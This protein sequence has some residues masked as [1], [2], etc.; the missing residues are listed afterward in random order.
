MH[1][2]WS[3]LSN[4]YKKINY[5]L[6][7]GLMIHMLNLF[8]L[9]GKRKMSVSISVI[10]LMIA[11]LVTCFFDNQKVGIY[12]GSNQMEGISHTGTHVSTARE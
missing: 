10:K 6:V 11:Q 7:D 9:P 8:Q 1:Q 4:F 3:D 5:E 2:K 12:F